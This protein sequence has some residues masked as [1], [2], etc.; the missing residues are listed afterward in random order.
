MFHST[1]RVRDIEE[2]TGLRFFD[3][4]PPALA[5]EKRTAVNLRIHGTDIRTQPQY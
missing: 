4:W 1:A 2:L 3:A 5:M